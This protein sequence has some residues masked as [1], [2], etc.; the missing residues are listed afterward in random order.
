MTYLKD[1]EALTFLLARGLDPA[2]MT[3]D[4]HHLRVANEFRIRDDFIARFGFAILT[5]EAIRVI[6][7]YNPLLEVGSGSGYWAYELRRHGLDVVA[8]DPGT[9]RYHRVP[10]G[11]WK[12]WTDI[13]PVDAAE[14][15]RRHPDRALLVVWPDFDAWAGEA[16]ARYTGSTLLYVGEWRGCTADDRFHELLERDFEEEAVVALPVFAGIHDRL[17]IL[18]R[19]DDRPCQEGST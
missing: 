11:R 14:A 8:T 12:P 15:I 6:R 9:G 5:P 3:D 19:R 17:M 4:W 1:M 16:L 10:G 18:R 2:Q 7:R 13:E